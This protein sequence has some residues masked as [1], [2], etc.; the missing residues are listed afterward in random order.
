MSCPYSQSIKNM[1]RSTYFLPLLFFFILAACSKDNNDPDPDT[2]PKPGTVGIRFEHLFDT[3][4]FNLN[5]AMPYVTGQGDSLT[6]TAFRYY[7]SNI[8]LT[9]E[10]GSTWTQPESY[11]IVDAVTANAGRISIPDVPP[12]MYTGI[13]FMVGVDSV[14]NVSGA[15]T[16]ALDPANE[17]FWSWN[18]GYIF[19]KAEGTSPQAGMDGKFEYHIG[20]HGGEHAAQQISEHNL[21][22]HHGHGQHD[23]LVV[24]SGGNPSIHFHVDIRKLFA[25]ENT[26][27]VGDLPM[28]HMPGP[29][30]KRLAV[31]YKQ[32]FR[33][34]HIHN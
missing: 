23:H 4:P 25:G 7:I 14:R 32:M 34:D 9:K 16:G 18:T 26:I 6:F 22:G 27:S 29:D 20:G 12:G 24:Q 11:Y 17:M 3:L 30:A 33:L 15:Q 8:V 13:R 2:D 1:K 28:V 10:D 21:Q 19:L 5:S 31:N